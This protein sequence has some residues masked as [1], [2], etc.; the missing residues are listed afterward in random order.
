MK[1]KYYVETNK[2]K[3][4]KMNK[5]IYMVIEEA[6]YEPMGIIAIFSSE[7]KAMDYILEYIPIAKKNYSDRLSIIKYI[8]DDINYKENGRLRYELNL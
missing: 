7:G 6:D 8:V 1:I 2:I 4:E 3:G 5:V